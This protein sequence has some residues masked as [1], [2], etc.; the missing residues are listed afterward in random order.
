VSGLLKQGAGRTVR[1]LDSPRP[2]ADPV[3]AAD[4]VALALREAAAAALARAEAAEAEIPR[5]EEAA[6]A[7]YAEGRKAGVKAGL[8]Q[9]E[10]ARTE[11]LKR[12]DS[13]IAEALALYG[14][15]LAGMERL[16]AL[17]AREALERIVGDPERHV[18]MLCAIV[19]RQVEAADAGAILAIEVSRDD[20]CDEIGEAAGKVE[21]A[22]SDA[23]RSGD[24]RMKM[25]LGTLEIGVAAQWARMRSA[26]DE[27]AEA[28][29]P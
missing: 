10:D 6:Q 22:V 23:L 26:L 20:F 1:G 2:T 12:L 25:R 14:E 21:V 28:P 11:S 18:E 7:A 17:I 4:P 27:L 29:L 16:A 5:L 9:A 13:G 24:C 19:R 8:R 3:P 15:Q